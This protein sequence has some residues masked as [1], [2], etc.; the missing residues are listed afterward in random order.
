[1]IANRQ[2]YKTISIDKSTFNNGVGQND[3]SGNTVSGDVTLDQVHDEVFLSRNRKPSKWEDNILLATTANN[4]PILDVIN[5]YGKCVILHNPKISGVIDEEDKTIPYTIPN[6]N[7][8]C[9]I[10][11]CFSGVGIPGLNNIFDQANMS[12]KSFVEYHNT[13]EDTQRNIFSS[14]LSGD[15]NGLYKQS[16]NLRYTAYFNYDLLIF[17]YIYE[18]IYPIQPD[19]NAY[20]N[21][22]YDAVLAITNGTANTQLSSAQIEAINVVNINYLWC[23]LMIYCYQRIIDDNHLTSVRNEYVEGISRL[24]QIRF[25]SFV[26]KDGYFTNP[27]FS[28]RGNYSSGNDLK[29]YIDG[30][31]NAVY[32]PNDQMR[33]QRDNRSLPFGVQYVT[34]QS[35]VAQGMKN[36]LGKKVSITYKGIIARNENNKDEIKNNCMRVIDGLFN[37]YYKVPQI[38]KMIPI[39]QAQAWSMIKFSGDSSHIVFGQIMEDIKIVYNNITPNTPSP[40]GFK[41]VYLLEERPLTARLLA[42]KKNIFV[43]GTNLIMEKFTGPGS[44]N[45]YN[46]HACLYVDFNLSITLNN[47]IEGLKAK[48]LKYNTSASL[49]RN[50]YEYTKNY[51]KQIN[52]RTNLFGYITYEIQ[53]GKIVLNKNDLPTGENLDS[54]FING[55][56]SAIKEWKFIQMFEIDEMLI[57]LNILAKQYNN[58][59][60]ARIKILKEVLIGGRLNRATSPTNWRLLLRILIDTDS[61][62]LDTSLRNIDTSLQNINVSTLIQSGYYEMKQILSLIIGLLNFEFTDGA[63]P[64]DFIGKARDIF[65]R[66]RNNNS[67]FKSIYDKIIYSFT[68]NNTIRSV[69]SI[70]NQNKY[71][72]FIQTRIAEWSDNNIEKRVPPK[73]E[74]IVN[75]LKEFVDSCLYINNKF[76]TISGG[77]GSPQNQIK[78]SSGNSSNHKTNSYST[79]INE[80]NVLVNGYQYNMDVMLYNNPDEKLDHISIAIE[81]LNYISQTPI[82]EQNDAFELPLQKNYNNETLDI[83]EHLD[84]EDYIRKI[85]NSNIFQ[86]FSEIIVRESANY[87]TDIS[88]IG[89]NIITMKAIYR[90]YNDNLLKD[91]NV[92]LLKDFNVNLLKAI[93]KSF[94]IEVIPRTNDYLNNIILKRSKRLKDNDVTYKIIYFITYIIKKYNNIYSTLGSNP[95]NI[96]KKMMEIDHL[97][98]KKLRYE[99]QNKNSTR[100]IILSNKKSNMYKKSTNNPK[101]TMKKRY[102]KQTMKKRYPSINNTIIL[103]KNNTIKKRGRSNSSITDSTELDSV[104]SDSK[105]QKMD[106]DVYNSQ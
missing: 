20:I 84:A 49:I 75:S 82:E 58:S 50:E 74:I 100:E 15:G 62:A 5:T 25:D 32:V 68:G 90:R 54:A 31:C 14:P 81:V 37:H 2:G 96:S 69:F 6:N 65:N 12:L 61:A 91:F 83:V 40:Y 76:S 55:L 99:R 19:I 48:I 28:F 80:D 104:E 38:D 57:Q 88:A 39:N 8:V 13:I 46:R 77:D 105:R 16:T 86:V 72:T 66:F 34:T 59:N 60:L 26:T 94:H 43:E 102:P 51:I 89:N 52:L 78:N 64:V 17:K 71:E 92:N 1:M 23:K 22:L 30:L 29:T 73:V 7:E 70:S 11:D 67:N 106:G 95:N 87:I 47:I 85:I 10:R 18:K 4:I 21:G 56:Q 9:Y 41:I 27:M 103:S 42:N 36:A 93:Q 97:I 101:Q 44:E 33:I 35:M 63:T 3:I 24:C 79:I 53:K 98:L 45:K